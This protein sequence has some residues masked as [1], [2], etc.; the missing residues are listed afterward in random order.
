[1]T[2]INRLYRRFRLCRGL[3]VVAPTPSMAAKLKYGAST[4]LL[5]S[6]WFVRQNVGA[7]QHWAISARL[8]NTCAN[9]ADKVQG[10]FG[11]R[12]TLQ[13]VYCRYRSERQG[14]QQQDRPRRHIHRAHQACRASRP[15]CHKALSVPC[16]CEVSSGIC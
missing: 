7:R 13:Q 16:A 6:R 3:F 1:M 2:F 11:G 14:R 15:G 10:H 12:P 4:G 5:C 8:T 9:L